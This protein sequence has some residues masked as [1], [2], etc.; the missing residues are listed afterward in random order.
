MF[1]PVISLKAFSMISCDKSSRKTKRVCPEHFE[2]SSFEAELQTRFVFRR[3]K[4]P[5]PGAMP[6]KFNFIHTQSN[7]Q[8]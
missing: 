6:A 2:E 4:R 3:F 5:K 8:Q 1:A 7:D